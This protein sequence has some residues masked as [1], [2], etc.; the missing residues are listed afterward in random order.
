M[1][2]QLMAYSFFKLILVKISQ[3]CNSWCEEGEKLNLKEWMLPNA[4]CIEDGSIGRR[5][6]YLRF[7]VG[8]PQ[9]S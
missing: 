9:M 8:T 7:D 6:G 4:E 2:S 1:S 5:E 3:S